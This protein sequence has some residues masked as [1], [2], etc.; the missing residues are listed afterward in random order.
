MIEKAVSLHN[1]QDNHDKVYYI[2]IVSV[3]NN[4]FTVCFQYGRRGKTLKFGEKT[5]TPVSRLEAERLFEDKV[6]H[7]LKKGYHIIP[8][9]QDLMTLIAFSY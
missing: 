4:K 6:N 7:E 5:T 1:N 3:E 8:N 2:E 9:P